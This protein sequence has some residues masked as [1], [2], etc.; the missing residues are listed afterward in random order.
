MK[1]ACIKL[2]VIF[3][4]SLFGLSNVLANGSRELVSHREK[5]ILMD[6]INK[7]RAEKGLTILK[8]STDAERLSKIR[9]QSMYDHLVTISQSDLRKNV[10]Q[11]HRNFGYDYR[12]FDLDLEFY[13]KGYAI[14]VANE[15]A[16]NLYKPDSMVYV[17]FDGWKNSPTHW[18]C[19]MDTDSNSMSI[20]IKETEDEGILVSMII[21]RE[22]D[23]T[24][25]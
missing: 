13:K 5:L 10:K 25:K 11:L 18:A 7:Y 21:F 9:T 6:S 16:A 8:Y 19:M 22:F 2:M 17:L 4:L 24:R 12:M 1:N 23:T 20:D 15:C 14:T 3:G